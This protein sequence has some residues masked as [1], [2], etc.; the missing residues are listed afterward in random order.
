MFT[1]RAPV[2]RPVVIGR[3]SAR[4]VRGGHSALFSRSAVV[5]RATEEDKSEEMKEKMDENMDK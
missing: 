1:I 2:A 3:V 5:L 4:S